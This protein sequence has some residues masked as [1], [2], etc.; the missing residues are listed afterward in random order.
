M[1]WSKLKKLVE[2][3]FSETAQGR[4]H[5]YATRHHKSS[6]CIT[7]GWITVD[8]EEIFEAS[9]LRER[10]QQFQREAPER[11]KAA[12]YKDY[13]ADGIE[14]IAGWDFARQL[15]NYLNMKP[16]DALS[17]DSPI[18][19]A[20]AVLD[21][22]TGKRSLEKIRGTKHHQLVERMLKLRMEGWQHSA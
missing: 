9:T 20:L 6:E 3:R 13:D 11:H 4:V 10:L 19:Q 22:R 21:A 1:R 5:F 18:L 7:R 12:G 17:S 8:G 16:S 14:E 2:E 15:F